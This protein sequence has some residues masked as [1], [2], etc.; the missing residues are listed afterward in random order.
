[1]IFLQLSR[2]FTIIAG[3]FCA[4]YYAIFNLSEFD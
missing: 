1:M 2:D 3:F 4:C